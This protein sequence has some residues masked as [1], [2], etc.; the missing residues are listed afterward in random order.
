MGVLPRG[1]LCSACWEAA[2]SVEPA[3]AAEKQSKTVL[4]AVSPMQTERHHFLSI[5]AGARML[6][7]SASGGGHGSDAGGMWKLAQSGHGL[8]LRATDPS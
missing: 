4:A 6:L 7:D 5:A 2:H 8:L 1:L 3:E